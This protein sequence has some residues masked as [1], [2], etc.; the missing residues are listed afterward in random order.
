[1]VEK[2]VGMTR[3]K[4][5]ARWIERVL[6]SLL[7]ICRHVYVMD[8]SSDDDTAEI[9]ASM[10][11]TTVWPSPFEGLDEVR[12]KN[13]LLD[14]VTED[15]RPEWILCVDGDE[16]LHAADRGLVESALGGGASRYSLRVVYLWNDEWTIR[17]DG[18]YARFRRPSLFRAT[19][20]ARF[21]SA[22][23]NGFHCSNTP[24]LGRAEHL[25]ARLLHYGYMLREDRMR[26]YEFYNRTDPNNLHEDR[27]RHMAIGD[28]FP[29]SMRTKW[30][31]PLKLEALT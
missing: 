18:I 13:W 16:E 22:S 19:A 10:E 7:P 15:S 9:A 5:E 23:A 3:V 27:Y 12:D 24:A 14:R 6:A 2:L 31:G 4:N 11:R 28:V 25:G 30:G 20:G 21:R 29:R 1:M 17:T 26:K 8:D